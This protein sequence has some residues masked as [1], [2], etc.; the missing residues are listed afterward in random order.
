M[1]QKLGGRP[2]PPRLE[3][4]RGRQKTSAGAPD[5]HALAGSAQSVEIANT[6]VRAVRNGRLDHCPTYFRGKNASPFP[7]RPV[8]R[9]GL[10]G[11]LTRA[12]P[13][14]LVTG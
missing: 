4:K 7:A 13:A 14:A 2:R 11:R 10:A 9:G 12:L 1:G 3:M 8:Q 6:N 5:R